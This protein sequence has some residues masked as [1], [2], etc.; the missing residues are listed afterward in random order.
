MAHALGMIVA[1]EGVETERQRV[2][3][4]ELGCDRAQGY[5]LAGRARGRRARHLRQK[6]DAR[7]ATHDRQGTDGLR[8]GYPAPHWRPGR[9][10]PPCHCSTRP[11]RRPRRASTRPRKSVRP[12]RTSSRPR[13]PSGRSTTS[14]KSSAALVYGQKTGSPVENVDAEIDRVVAE[15]TAAEGLARRGRRSRD[16]P[17]APT[18]TQPP[19]AD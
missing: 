9:R 1:A 5:L 16:I 8:R 15:I 13:R 12:A 4:V 17:G 14:R 18:P 7:P 11:R 3:L 10:E 2:R 19:A 6:C